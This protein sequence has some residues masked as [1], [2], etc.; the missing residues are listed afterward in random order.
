MNQL[1]LGLDLLKYLEQ[2]V[3]KVQQNIKEA[4]DL[5][6]SYANKKRKDKYYHIGEHVYLKLKV[7]RSSLSLGRCENLAPR[8]CRPFEIL[9]KRGPLAYELAL[10]PH[11]KVHNVFHAS[12]LNKYVYDTK[13]VIDLSLLQVEHGG[14]FVPE[15]LH[16]LDKRE[17]QL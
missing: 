15:P 2:L 8:F 14:E 12:L 5:Q 13:H 6:K 10:P 3:T 1:M 17:V 9:A 4:Q 7:K 11:I 16:I